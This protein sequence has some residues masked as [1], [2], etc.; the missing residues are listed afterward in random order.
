MVFTKIRTIRKKLQQL[1]GKLKT[2]AK[3]VSRFRKYVIQLL[4]VEAKIKRLETVQRS[5]GL[6]FECRELKDK[7]PNVYEVRSFNGIETY[8]VHP[9]GMDPAWR[10]ECEETFYWGTK[11]KH[12]VAVENFKKL[13]RLIFQK[14]FKV[15]RYS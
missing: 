5:F 8:I 13:Q 1:R 10:C 12:Q 11:C 4:D 2:Y 7:G 9:D 14:D 15:K 6:E 3:L